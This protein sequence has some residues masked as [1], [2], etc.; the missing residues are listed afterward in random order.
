MPLAKLLFLPVVALFAAQIQVA[1]AE[2]PLGIE[3][4][5]ERFAQMHSGI[6]PEPAKAPI[7]SLPLS[8]LATRNWWVRPGPA[9]SAAVCAIPLRE[10]RIDH[11]QR[12]ASR[13]T[14]LP[15]TLD[16]MPRPKVPAPVCGAKFIASL[17]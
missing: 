12:F 9:A 17:R 10:M 6:A 14:E 3:T 15:G 1:A 11:P 13:E 4:G 8:M 16:E 2:L 7:A 5:I